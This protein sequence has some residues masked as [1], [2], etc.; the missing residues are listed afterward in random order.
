MAGW[1]VF[2]HTKHNVALL[3]IEASRSVTKRLELD[4]VT[5]TAHGFEFG[6]PEQL[7]TDPPNAER[8]RYPQHGNVAPMPVCAQL[9][10]KAANDRVVGSYRSDD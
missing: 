1:E 7:A 8:F 2:L 5:S 10:N 6:S 3:F 9:T 4:V